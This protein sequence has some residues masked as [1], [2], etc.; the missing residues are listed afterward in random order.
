M[1]LNVWERVPGRLAWD[2][3]GQQFA[4][5]NV[6]VNKV[7]SRGHV[8]LDS[9][10]PMGQP[11][12]QFNFLSEP[13]DLTRMSSSFEFLAALLEDPSV[14][15]VIFD[16]FAPIWTPLAVTMMGDGAKAQLLSMFG[17]IALRGPSRVRQHLLAGMGPSLASIRSWTK[18]EVQKFVKTYMLPSYHVSGTCRMGSVEDP[19]TVVDS[20][21][22]VVG[23]EHLRVVDAS[24]FPTL[25][26]AGCNLPVMMAAEKIS[27]ALTAGG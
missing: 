24:I 2:P 21:G 5:L 1:L 22:R 9:A 14:K 26:A 7:F 19:D 11:K 15:S 20:S 10:Q 16:G 23:V 8:A 25:M 17:S 18:D 13:R 6:I 12:I 4:I 27:A 3:A